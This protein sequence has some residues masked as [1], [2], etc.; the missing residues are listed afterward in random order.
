MR[1]SDIFRLVT[2]I[3]IMLPAL[4]SVAVAEDKWKKIQAEI[5]RIELGIKEAEFPGMNHYR[6]N[7]WRG[8][9]FY[10]GNSSSVMGSQNILKIWYYELAGRHWEDRLDLTD[11]LSSWKMFKT[12][13]DCISYF[14]QLCA[15]K[16]SMTFY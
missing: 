14:F 8:D 15:L 10:Y 7:N 16:L 11:A 4:V 12:R 2:I 1:F 6:N 3:A 9:F 13:R 5:N